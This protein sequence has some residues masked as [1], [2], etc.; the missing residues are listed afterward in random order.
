M[1]ELSVFRWLLISSKGENARIVHRRDDRVRWASDNCASSSEQDA[2]AAS[3]LET[4]ND[5]HAVLAVSPRSA[6]ENW[7]EIARNI[8][9]RTLGKT[10]D[11]ETENRWSPSSNIL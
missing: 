5:I 7:E 2:A 4:I 6:G 11:L 9:G 3:Y 8:Q 1:F 10:F